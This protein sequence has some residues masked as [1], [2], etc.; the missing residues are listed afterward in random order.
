MNDH[1]WRWNARR[2]CVVEG[3]D[4]LRENNTGIWDALCSLPHSIPSISTTAEKPS[5]S[6]DPTEEKF[7]RVDQNNDK[8]L[9]F[10]EFLH[11]EL[12]YVEAKREEFD[13]LDKD[14]D[15]I[16][17]LKEYEEHYHGVTSRSEARRS[18]YF[19]KVFQFKI[20][21]SSPLSFDEFLRFLRWMGNEEDFDEDFDM[22]LN[23]DEVERVLAERFLVK[24]RENFPRLFYTFDH[25]HSGGL[26]LTEYMKFDASFPFDQTDPI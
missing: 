24:P 4:R 23:Q 22:A 21:D 9:D 25:D 10:N 2:V 11:M 17:T 14:K 20:G 18:E 13:S 26:D 16:V 7:V 12:A 15:G 1:N 3:F 8:R 5:S 19:A 6:V